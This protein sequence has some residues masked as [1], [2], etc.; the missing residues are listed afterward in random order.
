MVSANGFRP[1]ARPHRCAKYLRA[2]AL[3]YNRE[4]CLK[5][6]IGKK[7]GINLKNNPPTWRTEEA[8]ARAA[9]ERLAAE[10]EA[11]AAEREREAR[12]EASR[13]QAI[14]D[15]ERA[16]LEQARALLASARP[17][18][19]GRST[20]PVEEG[21]IRPEGPPMAAS[22]D[23]ASAMAHG[24]AG[25]PQPSPAVHPQPP[26]AAQPQPPLAAHPGQAAFP[27]PLPCP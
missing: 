23:L 12:R 14:A 5:R 4:S 2:S 27:A 3:L 16:E 8:A 10:R 22:A 26:L 13:R 15:L 24:V 18:P 7:H 1:A 19:S 17:R 11:L 9:E 6:V 20:P 21:E 25:Q